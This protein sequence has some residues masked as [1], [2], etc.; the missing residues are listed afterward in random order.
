VL[1]SI[2]NKAAIPE[3]DLMLLGKAVREEKTIP[4]RLDSSSWILDPGR[5]H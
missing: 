3:S 1:I 2:K 5:E 4:C